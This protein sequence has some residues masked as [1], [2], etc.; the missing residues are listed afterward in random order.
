MIGSPS[1]ILP[2]HARK[3]HNGDIMRRL[4]RSQTFLLGVCGGLALYWLLNEVA[5]ALISGSTSNTQPSQPVPF[6]PPSVGGYHAIIVPAGG[7][8][9][10]GPPEH[11]LARLERAVAIFKACVRPRSACTAPMAAT[12]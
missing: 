7:Q 3:R 12:L 6:D 2:P 9:S 1:S 5:L 8:H 10:D 11:V 4:L